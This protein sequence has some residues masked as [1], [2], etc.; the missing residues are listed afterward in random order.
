MPNRPFSAILALALVGLG[1]WAIAQQAQP[2]PKPAEPAR[3][4][5]SPAGNTAIMVDTATGKTWFLH[6]HPGEDDMNVIW[7]PI[8]RIDSAEQA[9]EWIA[10]RNALSQKKIAEQERGKP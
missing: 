8:E 5:V 2:Q 7:L 9:K 1:G 6:P 10:E 3:Y 4:A